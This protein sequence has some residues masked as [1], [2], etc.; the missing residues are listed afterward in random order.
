MIDLV[1]GVFQ[2]IIRGELIVRFT[3]L[4][5]WASDKGNLPMSGKGRVL[6]AQTTKGKG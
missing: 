1:R 2:S 4:M 5:T 6:A 3:K